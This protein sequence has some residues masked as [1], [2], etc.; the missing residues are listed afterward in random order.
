[1][2]IRDSTASDMAIIEREENYVCLLHDRVS[3]C[4]KKRQKMCEVLG[5]VLGLFASTYY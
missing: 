3:M 2:C 5:I 4:D 1:M